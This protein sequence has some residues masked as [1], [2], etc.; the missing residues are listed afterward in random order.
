MRHAAA[1]MLVLVLAGVTLPAVSLH[2]AGARPGTSSIPRPTDRQSV[3]ASGLTSPRGMAW[4][5]DGTLYVAL[6]GHGGAM[7]GVPELPAPVGPFMGGP[8]ASIVRIEDGCPVVVADGLPSMRDAEG[9]VVG[10]ADLAFLGGQLYAL[11]AAGGD[12]YGNPGT[13]NGVY[14]VNAN[15]TANLVADITTWMAANP[16][17]APPMVV[18]GAIQSVPNPGYPFA[19]VADAATGL[20]WVADANNG[21]VLTVALDGTVAV[22]ADLFGE[23][24]VLT[25]IALAPEGGVFVGTLT[26]EPY[27]DGTAK[28]VHVAPGG[29]V[30]EVWMGLTAVTGVALGP[31]GDLYALEMSTGNTAEPPF[32]RPHSGRLVR[33]A[34]KRRLEEVATGLLY[35]VA[36][37][38][39]PDGAFYVAQ[40]AFG[41]HDG[42]GV[43]VR[44]AH[45]PTGPDAATPSSPVAP[46]CPKPVTPE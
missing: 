15:G 37:D 38:I 8:T 45:G 41:A 43:I 32:L 29:G 42:S 12:A 40:P 25:G 13:T 21:L 23:D 27:L 28:V 4:G 35:P 7:P 44:I 2:G 31:G 20:L 16:Q 39:G 5:P 22:A 10:V 26:S 17:T 11:V 33:Q 9:G 24:P 34:G 1:L 14:E 3:I 19:M 6:A 30:S 18:P 46:E 36:V